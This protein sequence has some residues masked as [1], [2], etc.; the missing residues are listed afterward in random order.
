MDI[1][2]YVVKWP[3]LTL[4]QL[5]KNLHT[6]PNGQYQVWEFFLMSS[7]LLSALKE[8]TI[9]PSEF[10]SSKGILSQTLG[11]KSPYSTSGLGGMHYTTTS[12]RDKND[13]LFKQSEN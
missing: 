10:R 12:F 8:N 6:S 11:K 5:T 13:V 4:V 3:I 1:L 9:P 7:Y 2:L